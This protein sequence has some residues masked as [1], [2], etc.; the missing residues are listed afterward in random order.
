MNQILTTSEI[1]NAVNDQ[2]LRLVSTYGV[3]IALLFVAIL[4][5]GWYWIKSKVE[6]EVKKGVNEHKA[7]IEFLHS[8]K[9]E[10]YKLYVDK[11][12]KTYTEF[13]EKLLKAESGL[14]SLEGLKFYPD[15]SEYNTED[16]RLFLEPKKLTNK[17]M[18]DYLNRFSKIQSG[19]SGNQDRKKFGDDLFDY[20]NLVGIRDARNSIDQL[21]S[22]Y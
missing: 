3:F 15:L 14:M 20:L 19:S 21:K 16:L 13:S 10:N 22:Y 12:H 17:I 4:L 1:Q 8:R 2:F 11:K 6:G 18:S 5:I 9:I 7:D